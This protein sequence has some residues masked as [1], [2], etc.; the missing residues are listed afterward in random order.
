MNELVS[1]VIPV[2]NVDKYIRE[3]L[4]SVINQSYKNLQII[5]VDDGST[6]NSGKICDEYAV[7]DS[8][9]TVIHQENQGAGA[10][11]NT[12]LDLV[13]GEYLSL[14]DSDDYLELNYYETMVS[15]LKQ[16]NVDVVQC[17]FRN[18]FVNNKYS[19]Q[20]NFPSKGSRK[21]KTKKFLVEM[22]YDWKY[23]IF[24]NK[25]LKTKLLKDIRF[26]VGR[27][28][29]DEF[30]TYKLICNAKK[31]L[32]I[33][34]KLYNYRMRQ[35]SIMNNS[36]NEQLY[37]DRIDC[38]VERLLFIEK[39]YPSLAHNYK[40]HIAGYIQA[41][42]NDNLIKKDFE[43]YLREKALLFPTE[44]ETIVQKIKIKILFYKYNSNTNIFVLE[45]EECY[46]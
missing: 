43:D 29:D 31:I 2:Y 28:I 6:D 36:D 3:C 17:L 40:A 38:F 10:A 1:I 27:K 26:P 12:G 25:L 34:D 13:K 16:H 23:A 11:K 46:N 32:N 21:I 39:L 18:V 7:K 19:R 14:I 5:L 15:N 4:D 30:F 24:W 22:L 41:T 37:L 9:I 42:L 44:K 33:N 45:N 35:S 20:Y 8:R